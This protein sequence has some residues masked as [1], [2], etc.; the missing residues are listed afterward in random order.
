LGINKIKNIIIRNVRLT[1]VALEIQQ[2]LERFVEI[3]ISAN[4]IIFNVAQ[5]SFCNE[6]M[7]LAARKPT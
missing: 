2:C 4:N 7:S 1:I 5:Q 3:H 6:F